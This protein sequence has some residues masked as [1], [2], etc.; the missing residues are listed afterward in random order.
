MNVTI[1]QYADDILSVSEKDINLKW[2]LQ[3]CYEL[4]SDNL[5][6]TVNIYIY[7]NDDNYH[8]ISFPCGLMFQKENNMIG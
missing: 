6:L 3:R 4:W 5:Q 7:N 2:L 1:L 8:F